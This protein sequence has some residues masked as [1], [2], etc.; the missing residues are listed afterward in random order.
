MKLKPEMH[1]L[2]G[3][4]RYMPPLVGVYLAFKLGDLVI[5]GAYHHLAEATPQTCCSMTRC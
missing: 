5:R 2:S 1:V 4:A 3:I